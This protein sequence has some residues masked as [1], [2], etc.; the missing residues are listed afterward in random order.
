MGLVRYFV[1]K[2]EDEWLVTLEGRTMAI[3]RSQSQAISSAIVM[4]DLMGAM[5]HDA[6]VMVEDSPGEGL[7]LVWTYG[8]DKV[9]VAPIRVL[10]V[11]PSHSHVKRVQRAPELKAS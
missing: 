2:Q 5:H 9:P 8:Q 4:A 7:R 1:V 3:H 6:D 11:V 10:Q